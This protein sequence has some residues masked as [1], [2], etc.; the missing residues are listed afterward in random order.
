MMRVQ[1][2]TTNPDEAK[3][4]LKEI[5]PFIRDD[6]IEY[7]GCCITTLHVSKNIS[8]KISQLFF[9]QK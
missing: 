5:A 3:E 7:K 2:E 9:F 8:A 1:E 6:Q 4:R